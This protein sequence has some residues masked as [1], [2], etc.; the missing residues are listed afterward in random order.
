MAKI[1]KIE[2]EKATI[3]S[4]EVKEV[5]KCLSDGGIVILPTETVYGIAARKDNKKS[6]D[7][8]LE[9]RKSPPDKNLTTVIGNKDQLRKYVK[10]CAPS[11]ERIIAKFMPGPITIV[12]DYEDIGIRLPDN[13]FTCEILSECNF[14]VVLPSANLSGEEPKVTGEDAIREFFDKV[15]I[16]VDAGPTRYKAPSTVIRSGY[17]VLK[18]LRSG[19]I[20]FNE[21]R[22]SAMMTILFVCTGNTCRSPL[23]EIF[24]KSLLAQKYE[25]P[26][27]DLAEFGFNIMS[28]G[29]ATWEGLAASN[30][31]VESANKYNLDLTNH[32]AKQISVQLIKEADCIFCMSEEHISYI[33]KLCPDSII[34]VKKLRSDGENI[35]DPAFASYK[36]YET[37]AFQIKQEVEKIVETL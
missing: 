26:M 37:C 29:I 36:E 11:T 14:P 32:K 1:I 8:L 7:R 23:A 22:K 20:S 19:V 30:F 16:I 3:Y 35:Q 2:N 33:L 28:G 24:A 10:V 12:F 31:A 5:I 34:K 17:G 4:E 6:V 9:I 25:V 18:E 13:D 21:I 27:K 15:D